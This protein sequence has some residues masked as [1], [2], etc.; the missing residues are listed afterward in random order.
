MTAGGNKSERIKKK[1]KKSVCKYVYVCILKK[2]NKG[3]VWV[4][5]DDF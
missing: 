5:D 4:A 3:F 2:L 1:K